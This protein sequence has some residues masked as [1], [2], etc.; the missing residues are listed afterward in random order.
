[1]SNV[2]RLRK[3]LDT[4][5]LSKFQA[6]LIEPGNKMDPTLSELDPFFVYLAE[7]TTIIRDVR[8]RGT[9]ARPEEL[10]M[11]GHLF[12]VGCVRMQLLPEQT[13]RRCV[14]ALI[15]GELPNPPNVYQIFAYILRKE[16]H[17]CGINLAMMMPLIALMETKWYPLHPNRSSMLVSM[18]QSFSISPDRYTRK[19]ILCYDPLD[20]LFKLQRVIV[21]TTGDLRYQGNQYLGY[22]LDNLRYVASAYLATVCQ[23]IINDPVAKT[24]A[25]CMLGHML[26][27]H[28]TVINTHIS[29]HRT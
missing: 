8:Y 24:Q 10:F 11:A 28:Q 9:G 20:L 2:I 19:S 27:K 29:Q 26:T 4:S 12:L 13:A 15:L 25:N 6:W 3:S 23:R 22:T 17:E 7:L 5:V 14:D 18:V 16:K 21:H 1:M